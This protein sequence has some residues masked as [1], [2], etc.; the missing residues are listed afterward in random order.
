MIGLTGKL[1]YCIGCGLRD[2][3]GNRRS[4]S[5]GEILRSGKVFWRA[6]GLVAKLFGYWLGNWLAE[7]FEGFKVICCWLMGR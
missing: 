3:S 7:W 1:R 4:G 2:W 6:C 5:I